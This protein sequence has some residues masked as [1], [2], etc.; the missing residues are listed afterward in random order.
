MSIEN[1]SLKDLI[2]DSSE[3][4][5]LVGAGCSVDPPSCQP[6]SKP[7]MDAIIDCTCAKSEIGKIKELEELK[8]ETLLEIL[9]NTI[10]PNLKLLDFYGL[11]ETP[12]IHHYF[13]V[14]MLNKG[15]FV[16]TTNFDTLIENALKQIGTPK[17]E[18]ALI[19]KPSDYKEL[20]IKNPLE[21]IQKG[22]KVI[23][24]IH[25]SL[26]NV[27]K[28]KED[29]K[30]LLVESLPMKEVQLYKSRSL[31][32]VFK[33]RTLVIMG[34]S[35]YNDFD[36][37]PLLKTTDAIKNII[38]INHIKDDT[39]KGNIRLDSST[40]FNSKLVEKTINLD[41]VDRILLDISNANIVNGNIYRIDTNTSKLINKILTVDPSITHKNFIYRPIDWIKSQK[42]I[43]ELN[44][45]DNFIIPQLIYHYQN[46]IED[47]LRCFDNILTLLQNLKGPELRWK[48]LALDEMGLICKEKKVYPTILKWFQKISPFLEKLRDRNIKAIFLNYI[49]LIYLNVGRDIV[50]EGEIKP[51]SLPKS[52]EKAFENFKEAYNIFK[53]TDDLNGQAETL[54]NMGAYYHK[55]GYIKDAKDR[56]E[57]AMKIVKKKRFLEKKAEILHNIGLVYQDL[58]NY[59]KSLKCFK[60][61]FTIFDQKKN[62]EGKFYCLFNIGLL[63]HLTGNN[64]KAQNTLEDTLSIAEYL[65]DLQKKV[66]C[67]KTMGYIYKKENNFPKAEEKYKET[68]QILNQLNNYEEKANIYMSIGNIYQASGHNKEALNCFYKARSIARGLKN[69]SSKI[70]EA[71]I[72]QKIGNLNFEI[73]EYDKALKPLNDALEVNED[74]IHREAI[75]KHL[76]SIADCHFRKGNY[77]DALNALEEVDE[78]ELSSTRDIYIK[79]RKGE[80]HEHKGDNI[81]ALEQ[82][83]D[84]LAIAEHSKNPIGEKYC[85]NKI[86]LANFLLKNYLVALD[87]Y[88]NLLEIYEQDNNELEIALTHCRIGF[89]YFLL[90]DSRAQKH[91]E[92]ALNSYQSPSSPDLLGQIRC[93]NR[94]A[95]LHQCQ[96]RYEKALRWY[97]KSF[98]NLESILEDKE[99]KAKFYSYTALIYAQKDYSQMDYSKALK[100]YEKALQS[101]KKLNDFTEMAECLNF[102]GVA[103]HLQ[104]DD[105][106]AFSR[107]NEAE[108]IF[109][110]KNNGWGI[111]TSL[112]GKAIICA[113]EKPYKALRM[114]SKAREIYEKTDDPWG[115]A[116][117]LNN[118][119]MIYHALNDSVEAVDNLNKAIVIFD[120]QLEDSWG[121]AIS[122]NRKRKICQSLLWDDEARECRD[123][124]V[125]KFKECKKHYK[126]IKTLEIHGFIFYHG[127]M[128][129]KNEFIEERLSMKKFRE[130]IQY[131]DWEKLS[132][133]Q[134][135]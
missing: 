6:D 62:S 96:G 11:C 26:R 14:E 92:M 5:F 89:I 57:D 113:H 110:Q 31:N 16:I 51:S 107:I 18:I 126:K 49:G 63:Y 67:L 42:L 70:L 94:I 61:A 95:L 40:K 83:E 80:I 75:I 133:N 119:A 25:G 117:C 12:N 52:L 23:Y 2:K 38:W 27:F 29:T 84:A 103:Y 3:L 116:I 128:L 64:I 47:A 43:K 1:L 108:E 71:E 66:L 135:I 85:L 78:F 46:Q 8:F 72:L 36:I 41:K 13:L 81:K 101:F 7:M 121:C 74:I 129:E 77:N 102:S 44:I 134:Y 69:Y 37:I 20:S 111:A 10:D 4:T 76:I 88:K 21:L 91:Y 131:H 98:D 125:R 87:T 32:K 34:Y 120:E 9:R 114:L 54:K 30:K 104:N 112:S 132:P 19:I 59:P 123:K 90:D 106:K 122:L 22:K 56:Y 55:K 60:D 73:K 93:Q 24:K 86:A 53:E 127:K 82:Y 35:G 50:E 33:G 58:G 99:E 65:S 109:I 15:N 97:N 105:S 45:F 68:L 48:S 39:S 130:E 100:R 79:I 28:P 118:I 17:K 124:A 115:N